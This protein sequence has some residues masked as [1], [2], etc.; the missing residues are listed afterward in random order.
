MSRQAPKAKPLSSAA[1]GYGYR[2]K[3][4]RADHL[5]RN[6]LCVF[7]LLEQR[8]T[9]AVLVDHKIAHRLGDAI[10]SGDP[11]RIAQ[12][13]RLFWDRNNWQ[14]LCKLCHDSTKQRMEKSGRV[15]GCGSDGRP[16]DPGHHWNRAGQG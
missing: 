13:R 5:R 1:K 11:E 4:A 14:S 8:Q 2:W 9:R 12:A 16:L 7:C 15:L 6:P 3:M 10:V